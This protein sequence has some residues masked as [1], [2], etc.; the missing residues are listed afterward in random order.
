[1]N[2]R[3]AMLFMVVRA[4]ICDVVCV[5][6]RSAPV[7]IAVCVWFSNTCFLLFQMKYFV[8]LLYCCV[9]GRVS[10]RIIGLSNFLVLGTNFVS[11]TFHFGHAV[12]I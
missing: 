5:M 6:M 9:L 7:E 2:L 8:T 1:M 10:N 3:S 12:K 11:H 4:T